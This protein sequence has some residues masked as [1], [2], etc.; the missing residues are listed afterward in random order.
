MSFIE[1]KR[2]AFLGLPWYFTTYRVEE[3][4]INVKSGLLKTVEDDVYMY[5]IADVRLTKT[6][7]EK[8]FKL[9]TVICYTSDVTHPQLQL[10]HIKNSSAI[11]DYIM[12]Q[13]EEERRKKRTLHTL[14][15]DSD[16]ELED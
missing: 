16:V 14:G 9:G 12:K 6:L 4:V 5:K 13:S 11:K 15:I 2:T 3:D 10:Q 8:I 7:M 1:K